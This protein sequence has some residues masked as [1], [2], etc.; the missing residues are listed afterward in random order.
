MAGDTERVIKVTPGYRLV[1]LNSVPL[2]NGDGISK[3]ELIFL[4]TNDAR[5]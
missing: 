3:I 2:P 5:C 1:G 4:N